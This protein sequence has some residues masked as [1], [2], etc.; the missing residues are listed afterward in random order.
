MPSSTTSTMRAKFSRRSRQPEGLTTDPGLDAP[1]SAPRGQPV[2]LADGAQILIRAIE[3]DDARQLNAGF[4]HLSE[5]SRYR[6]FLTSI[7]HL[8]KRQLAFLTDVDHEVH[9]ALVAIDAVNGEVVGVARF[10][11]GPEDLKHVE[12]AVVVGR[13]MAAPCGRQRIDRASRRSSAPRRRRAAR[14]TDAHRQP[15]RPPT[16][17]AGC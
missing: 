7:D 10:V 16:P 9:E 14:R 12:V 5:V 4:E 2:T 6:R 3:R 1:T 13:P 17:R 11:G 15:R 8:S